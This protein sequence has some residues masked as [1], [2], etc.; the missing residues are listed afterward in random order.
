MAASSA[1]SKVPSQCRSLVAGSRISAAYLPHGRRR[2]P[3]YRV[4]LASGCCWR[5]L[6]DDDEDDFLS[7]GDDDEEK[8]DEKFIMPLERVVWWLTR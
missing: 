8:Y 4:V 3:R 6:L 5:R 1:V 2:T 7:A